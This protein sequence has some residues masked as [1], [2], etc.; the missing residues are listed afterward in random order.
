MGEDGQPFQPALKRRC[1]SF[2][3]DDVEWSGSAS[4][5]ESQ[6]PGAS[7][8][9]YQGVMENST[10]STMRAMKGERDMMQEML[11]FDPY[12]QLEA[13]G[14]PME[15]NLILKTEREEEEEEKHAMEQANQHI[16]DQCLDFGS[17]HI[18]GR[19]LQDVCLMDAFVG[20]QHEE[21]HIDGNLDVSQKT[22]RYYI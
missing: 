2:V 18:S 7:S 17:L 6:S 8:P 15:D 3:H 4:A 5:Y 1:Y 21:G 22:R 11:L 10:N 14:V 9:Y 13:G 19:R 20:G 12:T 16:D